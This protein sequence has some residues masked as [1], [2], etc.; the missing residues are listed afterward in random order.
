MRLPDW[1]KTETKLHRKLHGQRYAG[2][3]HSTKSLLRNYQLLSV[4]EEAR[5]PNKE[6]CFAKP[7]AAFM[8]LGDICTR[9]CAFCAIA[10]GTPSAVNAVEP[11]QI[12][13]AALKMGLKYVVITSVTRDDLPDGGAAHFAGVIRLLRDHLPEIGI[14]VLTPDFKGDADALKTVIVAGPDVFNH[15]METVK[16]LYPVIRPQAEYARSLEVLRKAKGIDP[17]IRTKSG[18]ML[19]FGETADEVVELLGDL[20]AAGCDLLTIGQYLRPAKKNLP[21]VEYI[22]PR[23]FDDLKAKALELGFSFV[24]SGPL[25]RSSM[26]AEEMY[27]KEAKN[28]NSV[29]RR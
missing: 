28:H 23:L 4:C 5:C 1:I 26:N 25:V 20:R 9:D 13:D 27:Y 22:T 6:F 3:I 12:A 15:N 14:E 17:G 24:A 16:R 10:S 8:I 18:F 11:G 21:V 7:T 2:G 29:V 19:G